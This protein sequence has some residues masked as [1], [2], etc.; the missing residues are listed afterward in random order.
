MMQWRKKTYTLSFHWATRSVDL[1][2]MIDN[3]YGIMVATKLSTV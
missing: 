3:G 2:Y 1:S